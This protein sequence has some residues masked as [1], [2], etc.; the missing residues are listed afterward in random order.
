M[1]TMHARE[2]VQNARL[3]LGACAGTLFEKPFW[4]GNDGEPWE[5]EDPKRIRFSNRQE[6]E[7][8][9]QWRKRQTQIKRAAR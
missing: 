9:R 7:R 5:T 4:R 8:T 3:H 1:T 2:Q 6:R